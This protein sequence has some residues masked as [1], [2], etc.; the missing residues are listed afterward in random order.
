MTIRYTDTQFDDGTEPTV[1][2]VPLG[3]DQQGR[4]P[5]A[6]EPCTD[7]GAD[8]EPVGPDFVKWAIIGSAVVFVL[9]MIAAVLEAM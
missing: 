7:V 5:E 4:Y 3:C 1:R 8:D 2:R 9:A 6:A